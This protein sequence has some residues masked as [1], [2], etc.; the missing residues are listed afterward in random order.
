MP[1][2]KSTGVQRLASLHMHVQRLKAC[3]QVHQSGHRRD[4]GKQ[5]KLSSLCLLVDMRSKFGMGRGTVTSGNWERSSRMQRHQGARCALGTSVK[6]GNRAAYIQ[7]YYAFCYDDWK[8]DTTVSR[9]CSGTLSPTWETST[10]RFP[11]I[12][13]RTTVSCKSGTSERNNTQTRFAAARDYAL[14]SCQ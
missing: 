14:D 11:S 9:R 1:I 8:I 2:L 10:V 5:Q 6:L 3:L 12:S 13:L 7:R 4:P